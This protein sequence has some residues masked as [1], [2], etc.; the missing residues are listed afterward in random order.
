MIDKVMIDKV[1]ID[2][3]MIEKSLKSLNFYRP[4]ISLNK[5]LEVIIKCRITK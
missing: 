5:F 3:V 4:T 2:K 1:M